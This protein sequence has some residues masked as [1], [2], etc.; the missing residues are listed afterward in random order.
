[1]KLLSGTFRSRRVGQGRIAAAG[2]PRLVNGGPALA[3]QSGPTLR[4]LLVGDTS[5]AEFREGCAALDEMAAVTRVDNTAAA[6]AQCCDS[7]RP[8]AIILAQAY[9]GQFQLAGIEHLRAAEPLARFITLLGSWCEGEPRSGRPLPG[10]VRIYWHEAAVRF[11]R[12]L[13][14]WFDRE[15]AWSLPIT[16]TD[17]ERL[18]ATSAK[19]LPRADGL[20][21][22]WSRRREMADLLTD[23]CRVAGFATA[24][25]HPRRPCRVQGAAA[26]IFDGATL[27]AATMD[28]LKRFAGNVSPA[29][30]LVLLGAPR[31]QD[32]RRVRS[33]GGSVFAKPFRI[34]D[35]IWALNPRSH[36]PRGNAVVGR[37]AAS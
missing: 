24:W 26:A 30:V 6:A 18:Q 28:E 31:I 14:H 20:V 35:L 15:S 36:A 11:R 12:D 37:S 22:I 8:H 9:P 33:L 25:M 19:P 16:A 23:T 29:K 1:M 5:R 27:D 17:E 10:V 3:A 7:V 34:D 13:P 21:A 2:P 32:V 4:V